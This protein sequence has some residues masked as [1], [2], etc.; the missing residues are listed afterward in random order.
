[1]YAKFFGM[2]NQLFYIQGVMVIYRFEQDYNPAW[3]IMI[4]SYVINN[5]DILALPYNSKEFLQENFILGSYI[6]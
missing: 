3:P 1:M 2:G 4:F 5:L 6:C